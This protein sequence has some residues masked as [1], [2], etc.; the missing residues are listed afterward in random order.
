[1]YPD[2]QTI[3]TSTICAASAPFIS[4]YYYLWY[5]TPSGQREDRQG[6]GKWAEKYARALLDPPQFPTL[7]EYVSN[8][9]L[10]VE[11]HIDWAADHGI[12]CFIANWEGMHGHA[13][14]L[15]ENLV[16]ILQG[17]PGSNSW[18]LGK[19]PFSSSDSTGNGWDARSMG[20]DQNG[21]AVRNLN[22]MKFSVLFESRLV[23]KHWP[24]DAA[25]PATRQ[26]LRE[27]IIY[28]AENFFGS[29]QWHRI[30]G[31]PVVYTYEIFSMLG[32]ATDFLSMRAELEEAV[33]KITDRPAL[34][35]LVPGRRLP[36]RIRQRR[37]GT[38]EDVGRHLGLPTLSLRPFRRGGRQRRAERLARA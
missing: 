9:P 26:A 21:F 4:A 18:S 29:P 22:R 10:V 13:K 25:D 3:R 30:D 5:F 35:R 23:F 6:T 14:F 27:S 2:C 33:Q 7:G 31:R 38:H 28:F 24:P 19:M 1:M 15:S 8:D 12:D 16:H 32:T 37:L 34:Q 36:I 17:Q 11:R 20:W